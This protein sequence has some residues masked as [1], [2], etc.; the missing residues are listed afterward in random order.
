MN[1]FESSDA[2]FIERHNEVIDFLTAAMIW[3]DHHPEGETA[4]NLSRA[5]EHILKSNII[6]MQYNV[7]EAVF[8]ELFSNLYTY[9][10][11]YDSSIEDM[12]NALI[13][14]IFCMIRRLPN[15]THEKFKGKI[16]QN[17][18]I[19]FSAAILSLCFELTEETKKHLVNGNLDGKK[20]KKFFEDFGIDVTRLNNLDLR[21]LQLIKTNRQ[22]LA[23]G[24]LSFSAVGR[25]ISWDTLKENN[26]II[27]LLFDG[28]KNILT[29]FIHGLQGLLHVEESS[30]Q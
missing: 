7:I 2:L 16:D 13:Y 29:D 17:P 14:Q 28:S 21:N 15:N 9:L 11:Q 18:P 25:D 6:L 3:K 5:H 30:D 12:D 10:S 4:F 20:I 1:Y 22:F 8:L 24:G 19:K 26:E 23:H 27:Q